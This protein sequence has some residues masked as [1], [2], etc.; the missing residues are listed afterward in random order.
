MERATVLLVDDSESCLFGLGHALRDMGLQLRFAKGADSAMQS[1]EQERIDV[2]VSDYIMPGRDGIEFL[3]EVAARY[4]DTARVLMTSHT[5][6]E[7]AIE[8]INRARVHRFLQK[9]ID[10]EAL[11]DVV[12]Q[13]S[14]RLFRERREQRLLSALRRHPDL[15]ALIE[16]VAE[17]EAL[18]GGPG[19]P[20]AGRSL[21]GSASRGR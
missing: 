15:Q 8:A 18:A 5:G 16:A 17:R 14:A 19:D 21:G 4:P 10:R 11:R 3:E 20:D 7:V 2:V 12:A 6:I 13:A 9:P 1:L